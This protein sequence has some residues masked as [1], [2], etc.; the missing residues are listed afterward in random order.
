[1]SNPKEKM[2]KYKRQMWDHQKEV[3]EQ[4]NDKQLNEFGLFFEVGCVSCT[5][6]VKVNVRGCSRTYTIEQLYRKFNGVEG[7][8]KSKFDTKIRGLQANG[9][10]GLNK[11]MAV[12]RSG[13]KEV[14]KLKASQKGGHRQLKLTLD[15]KVYT[16]KGW[17]RAGDLKVGD[18]VGF[19]LQTRHQKVKKRKIPY[20][21]QYT[22]NQIGNFYK[23]GH[24]TKVHGNWRRKEAK[25]RLIYSAYMSGL[26]LEE[27][28]ARTYDR[29]ASK[30]L[31]MVDPM[32]YHIHHK[33]HDSRNNSIENLECH[34]AKDHL[35]IHGDND[36]FS[37]GVVSWG[38]FEGLERVGMEMTYDISCEN[39][40]NSFCADK[41]IVH[42]SGKTM[43][44]INITRGW[45]EKHSDVLRTLIL[46]PPITLS[47]WKDEWLMNSE[48]TKDL[49]IILYGSEKERVATFEAHKD[50]KVIFITNYEALLMRSL[51]EKLLAW[52]PQ[53]I[54]ADEGHKIKDHTSRRAKLIFPLADN[55]Y[56][57]LLLTG[58]PILNSYMDLF[59]QFRFLDRG[60][61]LGK[62]F[63]AFRGKYFYDKN[64]GMARGS[65]FPNWQP[66][67]KIAK[68]LEEIISKKSKTVKK[69]NCLTLPPLVRPA[70]KAELSKEQRR[71][72][73]QMKK[74]FIAYVNDKAA[75]ATIAIVKA[76][77]LQQVVSGF[78]KLDD[79]NI[80][81]FK[82]NPR[83]EQLK[84][85]LSTL[86]PHNKVLVWAVF[87][88]NYETIRNVC[89]E[90]GLKYVEVT[91][92]VSEKDKR[93]AVERFKTEADCSVF[94]SHPL[95]GGIGINLVEA[96]YAITYSRNFSLEQH[97]QAEGRNYRGG[98][99]VHDKITHYDLVT[100]NTI[101]E[102]V[103]ESLNNKQAISDSVL[104][105][106][107]IGE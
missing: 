12:V 43:T 107:I 71:V 92:E 58:T 47:N 104:I 38:R 94:F 102:D 68:E 14:F 69:E 76:L 100:A 17:V 105:K 11:I 83:A 62:N 79:G 31:V 72:Y 37:H 26:S 103:M 106:K 32:V 4:V 78:V 15:H 77:R 10:V 53:V 25:H 52:Q 87:H 90:L 85:L 81:R 61:S 16:K 95:S 9:K 18:F 96:K 49:I 6:E 5:T 44:A 1:M 20:K 67:P 24:R 2:P 50:K 34:L 7:G 88:E 28:K 101:D 45:Y 97:I 99:H 63:F 21:P 66:R 30:S 46:S 91:G 35:R 82:D 56:Y 54:I 55:A 98:S 27:Y 84:E 75:V 80:H 33:D 57:R 89:E 59:S 8:V 3:V 23:Y 41:V 86:C 60:E 48:I 42:N 64:A 70:L 93:E 73:D 29:K 51:Y 65:Y 19:D 22:L 13:E 39:P 74:D 36:H 40:N